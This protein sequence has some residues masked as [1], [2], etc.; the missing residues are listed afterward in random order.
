MLMTP[1]IRNLNRMERNKIQHPRTSRQ[2]AKAV[3]QQVY[4]DLNLGIT[5]PGLTLAHFNNVI[6][7]GPNP[8]GG[9]DSR[10]LFLEEDPTDSPLQLREEIEVLEVQIKALARIIEDTTEDVKRLTT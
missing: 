6:D 4:K 2:F 10:P 5:H 3:V 9:S 8:L 7:H 1:A